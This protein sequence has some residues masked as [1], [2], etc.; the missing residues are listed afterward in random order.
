MCGKRCTSC[1]YLPESDFCV[2]SPAPAGTLFKDGLHLLSL[3]GEELFMEKVIKKSE[4]FHYILPA[5]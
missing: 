2:F 1:R 3:G 4:Y 5:H